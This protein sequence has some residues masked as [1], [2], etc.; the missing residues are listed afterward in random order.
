MGKTPKNHW[1]KPVKTAKKGKI[2]WFKT[3]NVFGPGLKPN[4]ENEKYRNP[5]KK[6]RTPL[7][8]DEKT[9]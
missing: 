1:K 7:A 8:L 5:L 6:Y 9:L 3:K 4:P 2:K